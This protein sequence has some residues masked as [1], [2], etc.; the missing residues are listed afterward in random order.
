VIV[1]AE[2]KA[3]HPDS[4]P[5]LVRAGKELVRHFIT[6]TGLSGLHLRIRKGMGQNVDH[7]FAASM[8]E[9]FSLIYKNRVWL[10]GR[11]FGS[12]SGFGS[13]LENTEPVRQ[14]LPEL[15]R[16]IGSQT[17]LD[18][19]CGDFNWMKE[20]E[21]PCRYIGVDVVPEIVEANSSSYGSGMRAFRSLDATCDPLPA[22]DTVLCREVLFHLSFADIWRLIENVRKMGASFLVATNDSGLT[23]NA[24]IRSGD[25]RMLNLQKPPFSFPS[26]VSWIP[27]NCV[28]AE[29]V[30]AVWRVS[31][32]PQRRS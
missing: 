15:L 31:T 17:V 26:P 16:S 12:L 19:G 1:D 23:V 6:R 25:F 29:R 28:S 3:R 20:V 2:R 10:N 32:L 4:K 24:D 5:S 18:I 22:A 21:I 11:R 30:L 8:E 9:R 14:H 13:E 27:D 7:L